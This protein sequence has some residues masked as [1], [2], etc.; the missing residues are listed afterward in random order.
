MAQDQ[1]NPEINPENLDGQVFCL[2][3]FGVS[4]TCCWNA[5]MQRGRR[6]ID[7]KLEV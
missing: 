5:R 6:P 4:G 3:V 1:M 7:E 2:S